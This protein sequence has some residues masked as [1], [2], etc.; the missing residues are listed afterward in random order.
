[1][2]H[3]S[4]I[5]SPPFF[6]RLNQLISNAGI[7]SR[8]K[9]DQLILAG[10]I[11]VDG[12]V[13]KVLGTK[14]AKNAVVTYKGNHLSLEKFKYFLL[15]KPKGYV[16][17][18]RD[19]EGRKVVLDLISKK[20]CTERIYPVG[21]L[22]YDTTGLLLLTNDGLLAQRLAHPSSE[23]KKKYH[24]M[25]NKAI[26][27]DHLNRI[28]QG[29]LLEDGEV[30]VDSLTLVQEDPFQL[31]I[32]I[33]VGKNRIIRRIFEHLGY[34]VIQLDRIGYAHFTKKDIPRGQWLLLSDAAIVRLKKS[35][36]AFVSLLLLKLS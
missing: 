31:H 28:K 7:C 12:Q 16:T 35:L 5:S 3:D 20:F 19:P 14:V 23:V 18:T 27:L 13:V 2:Q 4:A 11:A 10:H 30:K 36:P 29:L 8:R 32:V 6:I 22:D 26:T 15:N 24:V 17:T 33:H 9:A 1:M 21:R 34:D 25:L